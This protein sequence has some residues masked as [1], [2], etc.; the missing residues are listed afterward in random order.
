M[1][2][3]SHFSSGPKNLKFNAF[4]CFPSIAKTRWDVQ[5]LWNVYT[6]LMI[7]P[8]A[9]FKCCSRFWIFEDI[10][11]FPLIKHIIDIKMINVHLIGHFSLYFFFLNFEWFCKM[12]LLNILTKSYWN[13]IWWKHLLQINCSLSL[14]SKKYV[15]NLDF[16]ITL[17]FCQYF[18][19]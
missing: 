19:S 12:N 13:F 1:Y 3:N 16:S 11:L 5:K 18:D 8:L 2:I 9:C 17:Y 15:C 4:C 7:T 14:L 6:I 10:I